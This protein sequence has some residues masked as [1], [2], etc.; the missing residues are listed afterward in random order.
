MMTEILPLH[1][2][3]TWAVI[4]VLAWVYGWLAFMLIGLFMTRKTRT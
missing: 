2:A 3:P 1:Y 4:A